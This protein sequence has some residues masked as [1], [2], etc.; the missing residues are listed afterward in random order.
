[1]SKKNKNN[2]NGN[3]KSSNKNNFD[4]NNCHDNVSCIDCNKSSSKRNSN[5]N[6]EE[7]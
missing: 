4:N 2:Q 6:K 5:Q 3:L 7:E 1:M